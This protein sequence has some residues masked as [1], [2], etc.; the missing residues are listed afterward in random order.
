MG[1]NWSRLRYAFKNVF[2]VTSSLIAGSSTIAR[3][4]RYTSW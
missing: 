4:A 2:C 3:T 1:L